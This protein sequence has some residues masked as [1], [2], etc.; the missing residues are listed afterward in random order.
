MKNENPIYL[1][2]RL[3]QEAKFYHLYIDYSEIKMI[4]FI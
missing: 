1:I 4:N 3:A 2:M